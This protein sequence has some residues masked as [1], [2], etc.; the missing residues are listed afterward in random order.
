MS[1]EALD[2]ARKHGGVWAEHPVFTSDDWR[3]D[4]AEQNTRRSYWDWVLSKIEF[5]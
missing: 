3:H 5:A 1:P 2:L 4:I